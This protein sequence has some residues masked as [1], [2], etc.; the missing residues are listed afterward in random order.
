MVIPSTLFLNGK[1]W[2][3]IGK[4]WKVCPGALAFSYVQSLMFANKQLTNKELTNKQLTDT[5]L[6]NKQ[7]TTLI[8]SQPH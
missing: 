8:I 7:L 3:V 6:T 5:W 2:K 4:V 1:I